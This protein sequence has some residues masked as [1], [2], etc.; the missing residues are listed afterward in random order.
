MGVRRARL[1]SLFALR[2]FTVT[3]D[4]RRPVPLKAYCH[5]PGGATARWLDGLGRM[6][7]TV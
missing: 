6:R 1:R 4:Y 7:R 3:R 5:I 2:A